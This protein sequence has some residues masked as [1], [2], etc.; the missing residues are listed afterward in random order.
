MR[1]ATIMLGIVLVIASLVSPVVQGGYGPAPGR[2]TNMDTE[3]C[4]L[5]HTDYLYVHHTTEIDCADCHTFPSFILDC[6]VCHPSI[7]HHEDAAGK[8]SDCH[9]DKQRRGRR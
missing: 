5:C 1:K 9:E 7:D 2:A 8:C 4:K 6:T 3:T